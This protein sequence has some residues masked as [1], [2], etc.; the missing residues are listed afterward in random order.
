MAAQRRVGGAVG[1]NWTGTL[2]NAHSGER[3]KATGREEGL[4]SGCPGGFNEFKI[5]K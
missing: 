5:Q 3:E 1:S 2:H 4:T